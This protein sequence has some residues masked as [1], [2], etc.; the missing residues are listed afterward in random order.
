MQQYRLGSP[1]K[2]ADARIQNAPPDFHPEIPG[3]RIAPLERDKK[4][5]TPQQFIDIVF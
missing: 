2:L 1:I 5:R 4:S 3:Y